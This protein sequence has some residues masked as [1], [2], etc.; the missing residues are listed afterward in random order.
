MLSPIRIDSTVVFPQ[1]G[2]AEQADELALGDVQGEVAD[3]DRG[4]GRRVVRLAELGDLDEGRHA[5]Q[6][7][8]PAG[9]QE[10]HDALACLLVGRGQAQV[11]P[12]ARAGQPDLDGRA[13]D[14]AGARGH[15]IDAVGE[16]NRLVD[17]VGD[18]NDRRAAH[19]PDPEQL[20][21][22]GGPRQRVEGA[23][24]L[25]HEEHLRLHAEAAGHGHPLAHAPRQ[26]ARAACRRLA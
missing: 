9:A 13:E 5:G 16:E 6:L 22:Q 23:E 3:D 11:P 12:L 26:L 8:A 21:L 1:P 10:L 25:V 17:V 2:V 20:V 18:Q 7:A 14:G 4:A 15:R 24:R 19:A